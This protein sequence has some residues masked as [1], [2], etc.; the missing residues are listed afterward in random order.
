MV[1]VSFKGTGGPPSR[2]FARLDPQFVEVTHHAQHDGIARRLRHHGV[3]CQVGRDVSLSRLQRRLMGGQEL[4]DRL[5]IVASRILGG[6]FDD[7]LLADAAEVRSSLGHRY[8]QAGNYL[9]VFRAMDERMYIATYAVSLVLALTSFLFLT[10]VEALQ[11]KATRK[12]A[13]AVESHEY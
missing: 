3:K 9:A 12:Y 11:K 10:G 4:V 6:Q 5:E 8:L 7:T 13:V 2:A 1:P